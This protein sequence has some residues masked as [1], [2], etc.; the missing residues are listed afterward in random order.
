MSGDLEECI[1]TVFE[2]HLKENVSVQEENVCSGVTRLLEKRRHMKHV[3]GVLRTQRQEFEVKRQSVRQRREELKKKEENLK[4]SLLK[5]DKFLKEND[6]KRARGVRKAESERAVLRE[7]ERE[8]ER[9]HTDIAALLVKKEKLEERVERFKVYSEFLHTVMK[10]GTKFEDVGQLVSR[11]E[12]LMSTR[13]QLLRRQSEMERQRERD[14]LE[15]RRYV[16]EQNS[17]LLQH[18]N[19][20]SQLQTELDNALSYTLTQES[21]WTHTQAAA[22]TDTHQLSQI[23][24]AT[25]N[26]YHMTGGITGGD[27][28]VDVDDTEEQLDRV[29]VFMADRA[30]LVSHLRSDRSSRSSRLSDAV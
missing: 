24:V 14:R 29:Q 22:V 4:D 30:E 18:S 12:T 27:E 3:D 21:S 7:R 8:L 6:A 23:K 15:L 10:T 2:E 20:L 5:F 1:R 11:F 17:V 16:S 19:T 28:G 9:L 25:L 26:L 13:E